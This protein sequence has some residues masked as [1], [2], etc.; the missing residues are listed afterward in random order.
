VII[1]EFA[2]EI[3]PGDHTTRRAIETRYLIKDALLGWQG[4]SYKWLVDGR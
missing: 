3:T 1:K 4:F 2:L